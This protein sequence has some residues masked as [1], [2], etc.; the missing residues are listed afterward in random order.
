MDETDPRYCQLRD[1]LEH[2]DGSMRDDNVRFYVLK[3]EVAMQN[4][5]HDEPGFWELWAET[6]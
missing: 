5:H 1:Y 2:P 6:F 4:A 3:L